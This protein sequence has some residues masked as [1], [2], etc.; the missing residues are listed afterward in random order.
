MKVFIENLKPN[1]LVK[2]PYNGKGKFINRLAQEM[3]K[4]GIDIVGKAKECDINLKMNGLPV[5]DYG[6]KVVR[7]DD[8]AFTNDIIHRT[9][10]SKGLKKT[11]F[12]I[13]KSDG[14]VYQSNIAKRMNECIHGVNAKRDV[15][16]YNGTNPL[17]HK[18]KKVP[19]PGHKN[20]VHA[21]QK[22]FHQRRA[23]KLLECWD[24][25]VKDKDDAYLHFIH[26]SS[27]NFETID[28]KKHKNVIVHDIMLQE[29]LDEFVHCCDAAVSIKYQDSCPNFIVESIAVGTPVITTNTNGLSEILRAPQV[30]ISDV[31]PHYTYEKVD[32]ER[33]PFANRSSLIGA[34]ELVYRNRK[35]IFDFPHE[36]H[37]TSTANA[38][39]NFFL[40]LLR[41][42]NVYKGRSVRAYLNTNIKNKIAKRLQYL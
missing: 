23:D 9:I 31:D 24:E 14:I 4:K 6:V 32:W 20:Y 40:E 21:C 8:V 27:E 19:L 35:P 25:F 3:K 30:I 26:D 18:R 17:H 22:L 1:M 34:L 28:F 41:D 5:F 13:E 7:L 12:A 2:S 42:N 38:Y 37:I 33:P 15:V 36:I 10:Y 11:R 16:I 39:I 29:N